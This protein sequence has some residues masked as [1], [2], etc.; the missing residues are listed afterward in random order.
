MD[1][2]D[3]SKEQLINE[4]KKLQ[5]NFDSLKELYNV[6][7][8]G[9]KQIEEK[10]R[11][12]E[13]R[14]LLTLNVTQIGIWDWDVENDIWS[15][16]PIYY[17][18]LGYDPVDGASD[19]KVWLTRIHPD[20]REYV[21]A[22]INDVLTYKA[23][24]YIYEARML[25]AD[26]SYRW[27]QVIGHIIEKD[28]QGRIKRM[29]GIRKDITDFKQ[30]EEQLK[31]SKSRLRTLIDTLPDLVWLKD[32][33][34]VYLQCNQR[35]EQLFGVPEN[36]I[37]GKT[38]Y[39]FVST[40]LADFFRQMDN[41]A[42]AAGK[43]NINEE[44]LIFADGHKEILETIKTPIYENDGMFM[45]VLG[46]GRDITQRKK[47]E[48]ELIRNEALI[49][50]AVE[51]LPIV[52]YLIDKDGIFNLSIGNGLKGLVLLPNQVVGQSVFDLYKDYPQTIEAINKA[53]SGESVI[54][55]SNINGVHYLNIVN[56]M[57]VS[58]N[59]AG[60]AGVGLDITDR[61]KAEIELLN[62]KEKAEESDRLKTAFLQNMSHEIRT[63]MNA[64][65]GFSDLLLSYADKPAKLKQ[66]TDIINQRCNDLLDLINDILDISKI[67]SGQLSVNI[68]QCDLVD[69]FNEL[70]PFFT[71]YQKRINKQHIKL[72]LKTLCD[73]SETRIITDK[74]KLKQIFINLISNALKFTDE[75]KVDVGCKIDNNPNITFYVS[76][77]GIGIPSDKQQFVFERFTQLQYSSKFNIG[78]TGLGLPIVKALVNLLGGEIFLESEP[79]K[80]STFSFTIPYRAAQ[81]LP[82]ETIDESSNEVTFLGKTIL[83]VEDDP[84][85]AVYIQEALSGKGFNILLAE[86]GKQ[87]IEISV[88]QPIDLVLMDIRLPDISG[89]EATRQIRQHK[90]HLKIIAQ[91]A[92]A[93]SEE[94]Q[95]A[96]EA[97][98]TDYISKPTKK[99]ALLKI[100]NKHLLS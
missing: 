45:G 67:E 71:E 90:P 95:K 35:F 13:E 94:K 33:Q 78:G 16:S 87:A 42:V 70:I 51:N 49:R 92:Y 29:V 14:L 18:M 66:F 57:S 27:H 91:T 97:G 37:L 68:E 62:A 98:C 44:E 21:K 17:T 61:K 10:L 34:G 82:H 79:G 4:L 7:I 74:V 86:N 63:P 100:L 6:D 15:A 46:I 72:S 8:A 26:G 19:R 9:R 38:D 81:L 64:I 53:L 24:G 84:Y 30:T 41:E 20:D 76:D 39:D 36:N 32:S 25:H 58:D 96:I 52:F 54:F 22:K 31:I 85:N 28:N 50:T 88:S 3:K 59:R 93:A 1:Y 75:G 23:D 11:L 47:T 55:E 69:L 89:Y 80:G 77:T 65:M 99:N 2:S 12:N 5:Q 56:P 60:I 73:P 40:E 83:I 43:P 48:R